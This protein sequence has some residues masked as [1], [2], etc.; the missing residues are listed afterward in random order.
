M[1][2]Y[3]MEG[4]GM[5]PRAARALWRWSREEVRADLRNLENAYRGY[6]MTQSGEIIVDEYPTQSPTSI[7]AA[8]RRV[9]EI[10]RKGGKV[11]LV[12]LDY[13]NIMGASRDEDEKRHQLPR[14][15]REI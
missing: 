12:I 15:G 1:V 9:A 14:I 8:R 3:E 6:D 11:D 13:L 5:A 10:R 7:A 4:M 2:T